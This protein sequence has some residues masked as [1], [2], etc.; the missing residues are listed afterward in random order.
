MTAKRKTTRKP[1]V[2]KEQKRGE[3]KTAAA[4][5]SLRARLNVEVTD[6][7][8]EL[9]RQLSALYHN[10]AVP[11]MFKHAVFQIFWDVTRHL[12]VPLPN[13]FTSKWLTIWPTLIARLRRSGECPTQLRYTWQPDEEETARLDAEEEEESYAR[14]IF[15]LCHDESLPYGPRENIG[16]SVLDILNNANPYETWEVFRVAWP[17][18]LQKIA[19]EDG[20]TADE[21]PAPA[22]LEGLRLRAEIEAEA[23]AFRRLMKSTHLDEDTRLRIASLFDEIAD[24]HKDEPDAMR[25]AYVAAMLK[26]KAAV[27]GGE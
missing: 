23:A 12:G 7:D 15:N 21:A 13:N 17:L 4:L 11:E 10:K 1:S 16:D 22:F 9:A 5:E 6:A 2:R 24:G 25:A 27:E 19:E 14:H 3:S 18:A 20:E 26:I 8:V